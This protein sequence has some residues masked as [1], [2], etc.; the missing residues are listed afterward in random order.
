[1]DLKRGEVLRR[2]GYFA[3]AT[4]IYWILFASLNATMAPPASKEGEFCSRIFWFACGAF[5]VRR[6]ANTR[7]AGGRRIEQ[8]WRVPEWH[9]PAARRRVVVIQGDKIQDRGIGN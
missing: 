9:I 1:M 8:L 7:A 6:M 5:A 3:F 4:A 2:V